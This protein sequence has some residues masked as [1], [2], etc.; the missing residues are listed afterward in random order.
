MQRFAVFL[1][2]IDILGLI[3]PRNLLCIVVGVLVGIRKRVEK[4]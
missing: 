2:E 3:G 1:T 4:S